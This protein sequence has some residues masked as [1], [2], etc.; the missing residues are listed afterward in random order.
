MWDTNIERQRQILYHYIGMCTQFNIAIVINLR[1]I[2]TKPLLTNLRREYDSC[3]I[4]SSKRAEGSDW[5]Q[6]H[7]RPCVVTPR[8]LFPYLP[9]CLIYVANQAPFC[10]TMF[11]VSGS[12]CGKLKLLKWPWR[13]ADPSPPPRVEIKYIGDVNA[14]PLASSWRGA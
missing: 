12:R 6:K 14:V 10:S 7:I 11:D 9:P 3:H 5:S 4:H 13:E 2:T 8:N 1:P